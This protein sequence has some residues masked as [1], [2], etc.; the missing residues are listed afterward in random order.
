MSNWFGDI[1]KSLSHPFDLNKG[2][3]AFQHIDAADAGAGLGG[4][5]GFSGGTTGAPSLGGGISTSLDSGVD[6]TGSGIGSAGG[7]PASGMGWQQLLSK[8][9][10]QMGKIGQQQQQGG[11]VG[12]GG[13]G[14]QI[15]QNTGWLIPAPTQFNPNQN[16]YSPQQLAAMLRQG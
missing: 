7:S 6:M 3:T 4:D 11:Q 13:Q 1:G 2:W 10:N 15:D 8:G 14:M 16:N 9:L 5:L 12:Q